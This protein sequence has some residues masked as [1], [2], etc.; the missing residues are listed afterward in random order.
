MQIINRMEGVRG[1]YKSISANL[2]RAKREALIIKKIAGAKNALGFST[3]SKI[4]NMQVIET[5]F[6]VSNLKKAITYLGGQ[7]RNAY[8]I[9]QDGDGKS[10]TAE[11]IQYGLATIATLPGI[12]PAFSASEDEIKDLTSAEINELVDHVLSTEFLPDDR[13]RAEHYVKSLIYVLNVNR[14]MVGFSIK[15]FAGEDVRFDPLA[16]LL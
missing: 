11:L 7:I 6:G 5:T 1:K 13:E 16:G 15:F 9:D 8:S 10:S 3:I 2:D 4:T 14:Q 12:L